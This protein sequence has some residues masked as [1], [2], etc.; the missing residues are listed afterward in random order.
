MTMPGVSTKSK[1]EVEQLGG[2]VRDIEPI[3]WK[4]VRLGGVKIPSF[5]KR[6]RFSKLNLWRFTEYEKLVYLDSTLLIMSV[7]IDLI[8]LV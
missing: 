8:F 2:I 4:F 1:H 7:I 5:D 3:D 6:C